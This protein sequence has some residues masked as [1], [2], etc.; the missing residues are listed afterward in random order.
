[1]AVPVRR[2][3]LGAIGESLIDFTPRYRGGS[4]AGFD[5]HP[6]GSPLNVAVGI[7]RLGHHAHFAGRL[8]TDLFGREIE[9]RLLA[10]GVDLDLVLR[11]PEPT[12]LAFV[13]FEVDEPV[14]EFRW[15]GS[16][17]HEIRP[18]DLDP[19]RFLGLDAL[20]FGS[21]STH[22]RPVRDAIATLLRDLAGRVTLLFDPNVRPAGIDDWPSYRALFA[23][24]IGL[25]DL[26]K[27]S[28]RDLEALGD[29]DPAALASASRGPVAVIVTRGSAGSVL[30]RQG[31][32]PLERAAMP[33]R[34][35][36]TVGAGDAFTAGLLAALA[37]RETLGRDALA[38]LDDRTWED[39]LEFAAATA[40]LTCE[41][42]GADPPG[43]AVLDD[44][45][46]DAAAGRAPA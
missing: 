25:S 24:L 34:A 28:E 18:G 21:V 46:A 42:T 11:G 5:L 6:G 3:E 15:E 2:A 16:A 29:V 8:S 39:V 30:L 35:V 40:A 7:A 10:S 4:L 38:A 17:D 27:V 22:I 13:T 12:A 33:C 32:P 26:V 19:A 23:E 1:M 44:R 41:R 20:S 36:D 43:R 14:Y 37:E 45:L 9:R 31:R